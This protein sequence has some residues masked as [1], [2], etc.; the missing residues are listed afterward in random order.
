MN[1]DLNKMNF[2]EKINRLKEICRILSSDSTSLEDTAKLYKEGMELSQE[3]LDAI[4][5]LRSELGFTG[6]NL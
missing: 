5:D 3:C 1:K 4:S 6:E 2:D